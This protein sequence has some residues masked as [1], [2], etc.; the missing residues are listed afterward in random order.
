M[1]PAL[2]NHPTM[3]VEEYLQLDRSSREARYEY[4]DGTVR[5][6]AGGTA[7]HATICVNLTSLLHSA[8]RGKECRVYNS[9]LRV[10]L[11]KTRYVFPD[12]SVS[13]D[14]QDRGQTDM[15]VSPRLIVEVLSPSTEAYDRGRKFA[16]YRACPT[17]QE[18][19]LVDAQRQAIEIYRREEARG[20]TLH[21]FGPE[22][23]VV[24]ESIN[25]R[26]AFAA[27]YEHT[28]ISES[29]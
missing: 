27:I 1:M 18:Y 2:P 13:C 20:W 6:L 26:L 24:L 11:S 10:R 17:I 7:D 14:P 25:V 5:L 4:I 12:L 19:L 8:L 28:A 29:E 22:D 21:T 15:L 16:F 23:E 3:S 9:D